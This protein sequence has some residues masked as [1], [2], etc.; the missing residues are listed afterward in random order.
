LSNVPDEAKIPL[1]KVAELSQVF[2]AV[3]LLVELKRVVGLTPPSVEVDV[4]TVPSARVMYEETF[5][6]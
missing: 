2:G 1:L 6:A 3:Q 5:T 4:I